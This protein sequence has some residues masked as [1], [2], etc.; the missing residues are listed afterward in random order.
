MQSISAQGLQLLGPKVAFGINSNIDIEG[1][2]GSYAEFAALGY[3]K[4][5]KRL[6]VM[7]ELGTRIY[8]LSHASGWVASD[9]VHYTLY[10]KLNAIYSLTKSENEGLP[11]LFVSLGYS[12]GRVLYL[13]EKLIDP[14]NSFRGWVFFN[15]VLGSQHDL[16]IGLGMRKQISSNM[17]FLFHPEFS[18]GWARFGPTG[19]FPWKFQLNVSC[20]W[21]LN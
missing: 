9:Y 19:L 18:P 10:G 11:P 12:F 4:L 3:L 13:H 7:P 16:N 20:L 15:Q 6:G 17:Q 1:G 5:G 2:G 14:N 21:K 8:T